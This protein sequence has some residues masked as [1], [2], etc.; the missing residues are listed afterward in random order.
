MLP[1]MLRN[2]QASATNQFES[3]IPGVGFQGVRDPAFN[4]FIH[5][6]LRLLVLL[7][8]HDL[9]S[10]GELSRQVHG[11]NRMIAL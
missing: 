3:A 1:G 6:N 8:R 5:G 4:I 9:W 7:R 2:T 10:L 11:F